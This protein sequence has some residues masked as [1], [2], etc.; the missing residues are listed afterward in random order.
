MT[1]TTSDAVRTDT[2][3]SLPDTVGAAAAAPTKRYRPNAGFVVAWALWVLDAVATLA[4][5]DSLHAAAPLAAGLL[6][7]AVAVVLSAWAMHGRRQRASALRLRHWTPWLTVLAVWILVWECS[8]A[9]SGWLQPPYF[10]SPQ[11]MLLVFYE[12][13]GILASS[14]WH[15]LLLLLIGFGIGALAGLGTGIALGWSRLA[16]YWGHP[17]L[18]TLGPVP[19]ATL[20]PLVLVLFPTSYSGSVFMVAFGVWFPVSVLTR[21]GI[22]GVPRG[23]FDV[24]QT[25]GATPRFLIWRVAVPGALP[26]IFTGLFMGLGA[27]LG[28]LAVAELLGVKNGLGWYI[29]WTKGWAAYPRMYAAITIMIVVCRTLMVI[30]FRIRNRVLAWE[31]DLV[32]W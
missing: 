24:A 22:A 15:S 6:W 18:Q 14:T 20:L 10:A 2:D 32:R 5:P 17:V 13:A 12:D 30:L 31:K 29:Q 19:P 25:L 7:T 4:V 27:S 1:T 11:H 8:T 26:S 3:T 23:Y 28:A 16:S 9:K 21:A